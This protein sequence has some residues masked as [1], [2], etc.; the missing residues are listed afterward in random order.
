MNFI[1][2]AKLFFRKVRCD[3]E[4][5]PLSLK[6]VVI[7]PIGWMFP[8]KF[9]VLSD[10]CPNPHAITVFG[11]LI[12]YV[13][14]FRV[15]EFSLIDVDGNQVWPGHI[16]E[17]VDLHSFIRVGNHGTLGWLTVE[18]RDG[19]IR[20]EGCSEI[21]ELGVPRLWNLER[22]V[23]VT[24]V[25]LGALFCCT[26]RSGSDRCCFGFMHRAIRD[27][28]TPCEYQH[29]KDARASDRKPRPGCDPHTAT[30]CN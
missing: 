25:D 2:W 16:G 14:W 18:F 29:D 9:R 8:R 17:N 10:H 1:G 24:Q 4:N 26:G 19:R 22:Q 6:A 30:I 15:E 3:D 23:T 11:W 7:H 21:F 27:A 28:R 20:L 13:Q 12:T 5:V